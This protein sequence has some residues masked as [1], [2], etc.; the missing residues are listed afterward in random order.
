MV[1]N[2]SLDALRGIAALVVVLCHLNV[3][4]GSID[5]HNR[6]LIAL[7]L[8]FAGEQAVYVFFVLSGLVLFL[9]INNGKQFNYT[10]Y[11]VKR[12]VR[13]YLP[14]A[15]AIF[16]S[17][18]LYFSFYTHPIAGASGWLNR[19]SWAYPLDITLIGG[20][21]A[22]LDAERFQSLT[23]VMWSLV[24]EIRI[25]M[26]FPVIALAV[27]R[28]PKAT[29]AGTALLS[30]VAFTFA[31]DRIAPHAVDLLRTGRYVFLFAAGA[32]LASRQRLVQ[33]IAEGHRGF[34]L[35]ATGIALFCLGLTP[36]W[37]GYSG[38][39]ILLVASVYGNRRISAALSRA[40]LLWLG[41]ISYSLYLVHIPVL[42]SLIHLLHGH[43]PRSVILGLSLALALL[44][45]HI[46]TK[47]VDEPAVFLGRY[48]ARLLDRRVRLKPEIVSPLSP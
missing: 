16:M 39:A 13:L 19:K 43:A 23:N 6:K 45:A 21:L 35:M 32:W 48:L 15:A 17:A 12:F 18:C 20:H 11:A 31:S 38:G 33:Q 10:S 41:D 36:R 28:W 8:F 3:A 29:M 26:I 42:L 4:F 37:I 25:S 30:A 40:P 44:V 34:I 22:L 9:S 2:R 24:H 7:R 47:L 5:L 1:R 27:L 14:L 46:F